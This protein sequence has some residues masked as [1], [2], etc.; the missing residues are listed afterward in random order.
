[1]HTPWNATMN[2]PFFQ[3]GILTQ[4]VVLAASLPLG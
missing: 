2:W 1:L 3:K 4:Q